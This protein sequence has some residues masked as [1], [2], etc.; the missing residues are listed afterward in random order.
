MYQIFFLKPERLNFQRL[1][2]AGIVWAELTQS[3]CPCWSPLSPGLC[4]CLS[5]Q[6]S[7]KQLLRDPGSTWGFQLVLVIRLVGIN[8]PN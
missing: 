4:Q 7:P 8:C 3:V 5:A 1:N 6:P 2:F